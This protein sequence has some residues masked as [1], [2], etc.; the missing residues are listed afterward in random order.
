LTAFKSALPYWGQHSSALY[1]AFGI[2]KH[3]CFD[4][5]KLDQ[6]PEPPNAQDIEERVR[7]VVEFINNAIGVLEKHGLHPT[8]LRRH[9]EAYKWHDD[10]YDYLAVAMFEV[11]SHVSSVKTAEF[12]GWSLQ[13][14]TVWARFFSFDKSKTRRIV[15]FKLRRL[16]YEEI[17]ELGKSPNYKN[18]AIFGYC[19]NICGVAL[20]PRSGHRHD[21]YGFR[22]VVISWAR[23]N[24][25]GVVKRRA[26]VAKA[27]IM[28]TITFDRKNKRLVKT[29][30][31][32]LNRVAPRDYL[33]L[34]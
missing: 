23:D 8:R 28:G 18:A 19:L 32:G 5:Y 10:Y 15:L 4:V 17:L 11:I 16:L 13:Y 7:V 31:K 1:R 3:E 29:Y 2:I 21:E 25:L 24:Y 26:N 14:S 9:D 6:S 20:G 30:Q 33:N 12:R 34:K 22:K 27:C